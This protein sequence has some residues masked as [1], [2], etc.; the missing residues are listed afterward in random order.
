MPPI[1]SL[2]SALKQP[3]NGSSLRILLA[4]DNAI[5]QKVG[6]SFLKRLGYQ[7]HVA[8]NGEE[9]LKALTKHDYD[10]I[11]MDVRMP[12]KDGLE[13]TK[14]IIAKAGQNRPNIIAMTGNV[15]EQHKLE[16]S[17][18]GMD[19][20]IS[21][22]ISLQKLKSVLLRNSKQRAPSFDMSKLLAS[23]AG[24]NE[25]LLE[26]I[27]DFKEQLPIHIKA[28]KVALLEKDF[29]NI[30]L[31]S[32]TLKGLCGLFHAEKARQSCFEL[33]SV[34]E[35]ESIGKIISILGNTEKEL[36]IL[37]EDLV[38]FSSGIQLSV[39]RVSYG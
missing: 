39:K 27:D 11:L 33:E 36:S 9:V 2:N 35:D 21:K 31:I 23:F 4:E 12:V 30:T 6:I 3:H 7:C 18:A 10:I 37:E 8:S 26:I 15:K 34:K 13:T 20:F 24:D 1:V 19:D 14:E 22:P 28:L 5:N 25:I 17:A 29:D 32:H 16:C 38:K